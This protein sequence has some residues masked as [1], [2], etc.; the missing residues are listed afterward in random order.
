MWKSTETFPL[1]SDCSRHLHWK[2]YIRLCKPR[3]VLL[4]VW[5]ALVGMYLASPGIVPW[6]ILFFG[7]LGIALSASSAAAL[8]QILEYRLDGCMR[9]TNQRP[10]VQG[11]IRIRSAIIFCV[12]LCVLSM[13]ILLR[14]TNVFAALLTLGVLIAYTAIYTLYLKRVTS[15]NIVIGG[16]AGAFPPVLGGVSSTGRINLSSIV[17]FLI[18][19][20][21]TPPHFWA[22]AIHYIEDY[23]KTETPM[24]PNVYGILYTKLNILIYTLLLSV[25]SF[26]PYI[27][28]MSGWIYFS[29]SCFLNLGFVYW[30]ILLYVSENP[31][32]PM[33]VFRYSILYLTLLFL[34]L[35]FDHYWIFLHKKLL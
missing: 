6:R 2:S 28:R 12:I 20:F 25:V 24:L 19:F 32:I 9:R 22:L 14:G 23:K 18:I 5:T 33:Q 1:S 15:Q 3:I 4:V 13:I 16:L 29:S 34:A 27:F 7:S 17:L 21:W 11:E 30:A 26:L 8:N 35:L 10:I 31:K